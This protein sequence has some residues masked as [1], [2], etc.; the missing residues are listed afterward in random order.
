[1]ID[2]S[3]GTVE[4]YALLFVVCGVVFAANYAQYQVSG[5]AHMVVSSLRLSSAEFSAVLFAPFIP[6]VVFGMPAGVCADRRGVKALV[7]FASAVSAAAAVARVA[8]SSFATLFAASMLLGAAPCVIN[9][10]ALKVLGPAFGDDTDRAMGWFYAAGSAGIA[11]SLATSPLFAAAGQAYVL[12]AVLFAVF[13]LLWLLVAPSADAV[14]VASDCGAD[15]GDAALSAG[16]FGAVVRMP[17]IWLVAVLLGVA[18]ASATAY[19]GYLVSA[20]E[21]SIEPQTA[22]LLASFVTLGSIV[23]SVV[24]PYMRAQFKDYRAFMALA[25]VAGGVLMWAGEAFI[26]QSS[27]GLMFAIGIASA[28]GGPV[29]QSL[30]YMLPDVRE[31]LAGS[32]GGVVSTVSLGLTFLIP[33]VLSCCIGESYDM[34]LL[35][36][37]ALFGA[38]A[39]VSPLLPSPDSLS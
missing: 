36:C 15:A 3:K 8:C 29:V 12:A 10:I 30:P 37:A 2:V 25:A 23:G 9:A 34:L 33:V 4:K 38:T 11:C 26:S 24:G 6:A 17:M 27:V 20:L 16:A 7:F 21:V 22:G 5:L 28:V 13:G 32:A 39:L 1:M 19:S 18:L 31:G 35:G 14:R